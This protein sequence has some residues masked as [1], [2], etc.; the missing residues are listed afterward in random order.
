MHLGRWTASDRGNPDTQ[1]WRM[2]AWFFYPV[3]P[4]HCPDPK[5]NA[6]AVEKL[7]VLWGVIM[8][9]QTPD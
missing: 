6:G 4:R 5:L 8:L 2:L 1:T 7:S 9:T 3:T